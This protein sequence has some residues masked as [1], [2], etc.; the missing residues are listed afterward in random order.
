M[1]ETLN[2]GAY[3][4]SITNHIKEMKRS[5]TKAVGINTDFFGNITKARI[6]SE[7]VVTVYNKLPYP[8]F[9]RFIVKQI[10]PYRI[11]S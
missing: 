7:G 8:D 6:S 4:K 10:L 1:K 3:Y 11:E 2:L 9:I 5:D